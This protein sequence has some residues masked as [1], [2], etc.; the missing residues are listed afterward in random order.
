MKHIIAFVFIALPSL[1]VFGNFNQDSINEQIDHFLKKHVSNGLVDYATI[2]ADPSQLNSIVEHIASANLNNFDTNEKKA[3]YINAY[4]ILTIKNVVNQYPIKKP[5][6]DPGFFNKKLFNVGGEQLTLN[7]IENKKVR[8]YDDA[9]I[10]FVLVCA[11]KSC[12]PIISNAYFPETLDA[13]LQVQTE[14]AIND[15]NFIRVK[16]NGNVQISQIFQWYAEDFMKDGESLH[17]YLNKYLY[18][19]LPQ[20]TKISYYNY[21]WELNGL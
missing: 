12:P 11:A 13:Q 21:N 17:D 8:I 9:R 15:K 16:E 1:V 14:K 3:F 19:P 20:K 10:H 5:I 2:H 6:N 18:D 4:N 7:D